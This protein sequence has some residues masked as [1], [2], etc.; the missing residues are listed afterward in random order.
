MVSSQIQLV[1]YVLPTRF[2][3]VMIHTPQNIWMNISSYSCNSDGLIWFLKEC[4]LNDI[5][6]LYLFIYHIYLI[7]MS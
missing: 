4:G 6:I 7:D 5:L 1:S 2:S 3:L